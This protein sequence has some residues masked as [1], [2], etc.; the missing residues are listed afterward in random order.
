MVHKPQRQTGFVCCSRSCGLLNVFLRNTFLSCMLAWRWSPPPQAPYSCQSSLQAQCASVSWSKKTFRRPQHAAS[1]QQWPANKLKS[2]LI[3]KKLTKLGLG[4]SGDKLLLSH[5][6]KWWGTLGAAVLDRLNVL[7]PW[8]PL[9]T[10]LELEAC[11]HTALFILSLLKTICLWFMGHWAW[12][13]QL[14]WQAGY[15][16]L[17]L[18][19]P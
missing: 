11:F 9:Q 6:L 16:L 15:I 17:G 10:Y 14:C 12:A 5:Q 2:A 4:F 3:C 13:N 19:Q 18:M 8:H 7:M 1:Y